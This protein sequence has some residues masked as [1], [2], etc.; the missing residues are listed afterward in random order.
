MKIILNRTRKS[1]H[2]ANDGAILFALH[3]L[4]SKLQKM[5]IKNEI[6]DDGDTVWWDASQVQEFVG[7]SERTLYRYQHKGMLGMVRKENGKRLFLQ[8]NVECFKRAYWNL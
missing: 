3:M 7:I 6:A 1:T 4:Y 5:Q 8:T 2:K